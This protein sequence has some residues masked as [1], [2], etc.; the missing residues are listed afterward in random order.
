MRSTISAGIAVAAVAALAACSSGGSHSHAAAAA[1]SIAA[2]PTFSADAH[3]AAG[4]LKG[5][6]KAHPTIDGTK[7]CVGAAVPKAQRAATVK[8]LATVYAAD[9][10]HTTVH[11]VKARAGQAWQVF[12]TS[13]I[14]GYSGNLCLPANLR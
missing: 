7:A 14:P 9:L 13:S 2:N 4:I 6:A 12:T 10:E 8:C 3:A 1:S 11:G 5:C